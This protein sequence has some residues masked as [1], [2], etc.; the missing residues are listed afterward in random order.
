MI[1]YWLIEEMNS[2]DVDCFPY[3]QSIE[4]KSLDLNTMRARDNYTYRKFDGRF[5]IL[6]FS[7]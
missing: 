2:F 5:H 3:Q 4:F 6:P 7:E 1:S